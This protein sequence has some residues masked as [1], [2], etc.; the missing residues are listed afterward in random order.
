[1]KSLEFTLLLLYQCG[2][3]CTSMTNAQESSAYQTNH[4]NITKV[5]RII[6]DKKHSFYRIKRIFSI[7]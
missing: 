5:E 6:D 7:C 2:N 1:M 3:T 4:T